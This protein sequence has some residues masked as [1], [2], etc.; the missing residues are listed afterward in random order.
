MEDESIIYMLETRSFIYALALIVKNS[1]KDG[2]CETKQK[3]GRQQST[4]LEHRGNI[5]PSK[6]SSTLGS[7]AKRGTVIFTQTQTNNKTDYS[8]FDDLKHYFRGQQAPM[9]ANF[10]NLQPVKAIAKA[11]KK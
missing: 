9:T 4:S 1:T 3:E 10:P 7:D 11:E 8:Y 2:S 5:L 6:S